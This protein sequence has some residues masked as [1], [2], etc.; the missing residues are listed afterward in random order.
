MVL[1]GR[2]LGRIMSGASRL[3]AGDAPGE[4]L[5]A[6]R[7]RGPLR[8]LLTTHPKAVD[9]AVVLP[10][11]AVALITV[12]LHREGNAAGHVFAAGLLAPLVWRRSRPLAVFAV[13]AAIAFAQW[14]A[15]VTSPGD[16]ALLVALYTVAASR[17]RRCMLL[18]AGV[19]EVGAV[20]AAARWGGPSAQSA[21]SAFVFLT[22]MVIAACAT[23]V[24][25]G[26]RRARLAYLEDRAARLEREHDQQIRLGAAAERARIAREMHDIV[27]H[28]LSVIITL[29]DG[30]GLT[31]DTDPA[32]AGR[33][34]EAISE[35]G[36]EALG[37][38]RRLLGVLRDDSEQDTRAPQ[39]GLRDLDRLVEQV[40]ATGLPV[41]LEIGGEPRA[42][43]AGAELT[44]FRLVQEALTN[45]LKHGGPAAAARVRLRHHPRG[46]DVEIVDSGDGQ[47][48][49]VLA[50][51]TVPSPEPP[52]G[53]H[54][55]G[56]GK[57]N[58]D[59][60]SHRLGRQDR[61]S[62][63]RWGR[64]GQGLI[65]M[66]ERVATFGGLVEA[67][68]RPAGGWRV[69]AHFPAGSDQ[70]SAPDTGPVPGPDAA[71]VPDPDLGLD[72]DR[73]PDP[74]SAP[75]PHPG[76]APRAGVPEPA[77]TERG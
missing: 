58:H 46:L 14:L 25:I 59:K 9:A 56:D 16:A 20:L 76:H 8:R 44:V 47:Y 67:G 27:A 77:G 45:T 63:E 12:G 1:S 19:V 23:G 48:R 17:S 65:G 5:P 75:D 41:S 33:A 28:N 55:G 26:E 43:S 42:L 60:G 72:P 64:G 62:G 31:L 2:G 36:R 52:A 18:A 61:G 10:L 69:H 6:P 7:P 13:I 11:A 30:V 57:G 39:P 32:V 21:F 38:M 66:R 68:P 70:E 3:P 40:R 15:G 50:A 34:A 37:E 54:R 22:G 53:P 35:T 24:N 71:P 74:D 4:S 51:G 49:P 73:A 29:A